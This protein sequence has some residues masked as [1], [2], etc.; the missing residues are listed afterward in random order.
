MTNTKP[1]I[2]VATACEKVLHEKDNVLSA[3]RLVDIFT[4]QEPLPGFYGKV[5]IEVTALVMLKAG[6]LVG[7][8][9]LGLQIADPN[10]KITKAPQKWPV[11]LNGGGHGT[12]IIVTLHISTESLG[13]NW[14]E[15][16]WGKDEE[17]LTKFPITLKRQPDDAAKIDMQ[18]SL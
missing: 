3:I 14:V 8:F 18:T 6:D 9:E 12:N 10:G 7:E 1:Y 16:L 4:V 17:V 13:L 11:L 5:F 2:S 15:V